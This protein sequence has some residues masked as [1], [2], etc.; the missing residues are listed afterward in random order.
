MTDASQ[1]NSTRQS[2]GGSPRGDVDSSAAD[3]SV[4]VESTRTK[5]RKPRRR[6]SH[7]KLVPETKELRE[8]LRERCRAEVE[9]LDKTQPVGKDDMET[10]ARRIL[11]E[12]ELGEGYVGWMM[13][14]L[15]SA[16]WQDQVAAVPC[17]RRLLLLP[18][19]LKHA[20]GC[21]ADY[22]QFGLD[23]ERCGAC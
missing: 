9:Q 11:S 17:E 22:D 2:Q 8:Q 21:P 4:A 18:H 5:V 13:V 15:A 16:F 23:C 19:C 10:L 20:E 12:Q 3:S 6:T 7:L 1:P 14:V